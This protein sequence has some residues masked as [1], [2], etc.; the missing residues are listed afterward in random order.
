MKKALL[1]L[2]LGFVS[3]ASVFAYNT[4]TVQG[5][6]TTNTHWTNDQQ[7]LLKGYVYVTSGAILTIDSGCIIKG[8][9]GSKGSLIVERGAK[10]IAIG[11]PTAPIVFTSNQP[12]GQRTYGEIGRAHV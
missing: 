6:I 5:E 7:Y 12:A 10:L 1:T 4:T 8:D 2:A 9:K 11:T 3:A